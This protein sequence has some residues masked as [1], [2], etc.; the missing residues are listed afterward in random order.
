MEQVSFGPEIQFNENTSLDMSYVG[1]FARKMN[2]LRNAN[3]GIL[4]GSFDSSGKPIVTFP[5]A[6]LNDSAGNHAVLELATNDGN[7]NYNAL[8]VSL[9][10]RFAKGASYG[11]SYTW[12]HNISDF[13]DNLTGGAFP[14]NA[15][16]YAAERG[17]SMF[18]VRHRLVG[19]LTYALPFGKM[20]M[21]R[22]GAANAVLGGWQVNTIVTRQ[23]GTTIQLSAPDFSG[24]G[25]F[26]SRPDCIGNARSGAS[27]DPR[28]GLWLN[29]AAFALPASGNFGNCHVGKYHGPGF[30]NVDLSLF[31]SFPVGETMR[32]EFRAEAFNALN[33]ASFGNPSAFFP[34]G[35]FGTISS[36]IIDPREL[37]L[38]LKFYF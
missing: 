15:Y 33:H 3:Q 13:V 6:N 36:T 23:S 9:K 10:R 22:G 34:S 18:D 14:Q 2:R 19:Y 12:S 21:D 27:H 20:Y 17:D 1:N 35:S 38:A 31:K 16:N 4:T 8:L 5:Y 25:S 29:P 11:L 7:S 37:Q 28:R 26:N 32:F 24:T 30:T